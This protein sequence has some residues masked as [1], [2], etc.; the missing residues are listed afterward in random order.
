MSTTE[1]SLKTTGFAA[2]T[3]RLTTPVTRG[4]QQLN[5]REGKE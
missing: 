2:E 1:D 5:I 4:V 3:H